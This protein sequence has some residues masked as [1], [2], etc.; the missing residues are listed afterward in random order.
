MPPAALGRRLPARS[1]PSPARLP[2]A[3]LTPAL[4]PTLSPAAQVGGGA[5]LRMENIFGNSDTTSDTDILRAMRNCVTSLDEL[6][7]TTGLPYR[8]VVS[9]SL[10]GEG[11]IY[12]TD[13]YMNDTYSRGDILYV[14]AA[15]NDG[16]PV[17]EYPASN[18]NCISV[19]AVD[20]TGRVADFSTYNKKVR[21]AAEGVGWVV[22]VGWWGR[23]RRGVWRGLVSGNGRRWAAAL[24]DHV[25]AKG[26]AAPQGQHEQQHTSAASTSTTTPARPPT[27]PPHQHSA[28]APS[29]APSHTPQRPH[30]HCPP[31]QVELSAPGVDILSTISRNADGASRKSGSLALSPVPSGYDTNMPPGVADASGVGSVAAQLVDCGLG[32]APCAGARGKVCLIQRG[33][34]R[35]RE[36]ER[37]PGLAGPAVPSGAARAGWRR[38]ARAA[39]P[40]HAAGAQRQAQHTHS[41]TPSHPHAPLP[42]PHPHHPR[43]Q[44]VLPEGAELHERRRHRRHHLPALRHPRVHRAVRIHA[45]RRLLHRQRLRAHAGPGARAGRGARRGLPLLAE[46]ARP[47]VQHRGR[48]GRARPHGAGTP[49]E[50]RCWPPLLTIH[51]PPL[52]LPQALR[53]ALQAGAYLEVTLNVRSSSYSPWGTMDGTSMATPHVAGV[54]GLVWAAFPRCTNDDVRRALQVRAAAAAPPGRSTCWRPRQLP[55]PHHAPPPL[56]D[57]ETPPEPRA[58]P[59]GDCQGRGHPRARCVLRFRSRAGARRV[60]LPSAPALRLARPR[61]HARLAAQVAA[62]AAAAQATAAAAAQAAAAVAAPAGAPAAPAAAAQVAAAEAVAAQAPAAAQEAA[63]RGA[64]AGQPRRH[65]GQARRG[66][67]YRAGS[68]PAQV[69]CG[70]YGSS[71]SSRRSSRRRASRGAAVGPSARRCAAGGQPSGPGA[72]VCG[73]CGGRAAAPASSQLLLHNTAS[74]SAAGAT[75]H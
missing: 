44:P 10:G 34:R 58:C 59:A 15:G 49:A 61:L 51:A 7:R 63:R 18:A 11:Y 30:P 48:S 66:W 4:P 31:P 55:A 46:R 35:G 28:P 70:L 42:H 8:M 2:D 36:Q 16:S 19:G 72:L 6:K 24:R 3:R 13:K 65:R 47:A 1:R 39:A 27:A 29:P 17:L 67:R 69:S 64:A 14:A 60:R 32:T 54:A 71:S 5:K 12:S 52:P 25:P 57:P 75:R 33:A 40:R 73:P 74:L 20:Q 50:R 68:G 53:A 41:L 26:A 21:R 45:Q 22:V 38:C 43:H 62:V 56:L 37:V 23:G 9:M